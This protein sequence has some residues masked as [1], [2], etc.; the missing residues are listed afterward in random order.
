MEPAGAP[1]MEAYDAWADRLFS[2]Y[3]DSMESQRDYGH[4]N[5]GDW[6]GERFVNWGNHEYDTPLQLLINYA[7]TGDLRYFHLGDAAAR[8][9]SEVDVVHFMNDDLV[10]H[11]AT[12]SQP[13]FYPA[14][15]G[16][17]HQHTVGHV[18]GFYTKDEIRDFVRAADE[19]FRDVETFYVC[20]DPFNLGHIWTLGMARAYFLTGNPFLKETVMKIGDNL[21][22]L[23]EDDEHNM[24]GHSHGGRM[25]GWTLIA[26]QGAYEV[27]QEQRYLDAMRTLSYRA[28]DAQDPNCG[29]WLYHPMEN[30]HCNCTIKHTGMATFIT[31]VMIDGIAAYYWMSRDE[32]V[33]EALNRAATFMNSDTWVEQGRSWRY[34]SC[35]ATR[36][37]GQS[38]VIIMALVNAIRMKRDA[39]L[40]RI[41]HI[42]WAD[43]FERYRDGEFLQKA[44]GQ[45]KLYTSLILG[46]A[47]T[48]SLLAKLDQEER[49]P[50]EG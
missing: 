12:T 3:I 50:A 39:E 35:P 21:A 15:P 42:A 37:T 7:R 10:A 27:S 17:V 36:V 46:C 18:S 40:E 6:Y 20:T 33:P 4:L 45:G 23:I 48:V 26:L 44:Q 47:E 5:W 28:L 11:L 41:L 32:R 2:V 13:K 49:P 43:K 30:G 25:V 29:G 16:I 9:M 1:G 34:T 22:Q 8:H 14:R 19:R 38:G 31:G 24:T